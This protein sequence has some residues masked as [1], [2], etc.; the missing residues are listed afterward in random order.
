MQWLAFLI[1]DNMLVLVIVGLGLALILG[2]VRPGWVMGTLGWL[3]GIVILTP[4]I[5]A[6]IGALPWWILLI[7]VVFLGFYLLRMFLEL[8]LGRE[9]AGRVMGQLAL[10]ILI[11]PFKVLRSFISG[12]RR[13]QP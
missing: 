2:L 3:L 8:L 7:L 13:N 6:F 1:P 4:F 5:E 11:F 9:G 12:R 10:T